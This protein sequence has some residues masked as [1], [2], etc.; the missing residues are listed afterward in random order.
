MIKK[1]SPL[2]ILILGYLAFITIGALLLLMPFTH[3]GELNFT[4]A[5]F[6]STSAVCVTGLIV[7][8]TA[9]FFTPWGKAI[10]LFLLQIG[11]IGYMTVATL[12]LFILKGKTSL[13]FRVTALQSFPELTFSSLKSFFKTIIIITFVLEIAGTFILFLAMRHIYS[14]EHAMFYS[15]FNSVSAFCNAGFSTFAESLVNFRENPA[16]ILTIAFLIISGGIGFYVYI[17]IYHRYIKRDKRRLSLHTK[18]VFITT[19][20]LLIG[21]TLLFLVSEY[22][23]SMMGLSLKSKIL[24]A[25][26]Q[27]VTT[28]TAGF[29]TIDQSRLSPFGA[30]LSMFLMFVGGSPGGTAGGIKTTTILAVLLWQLSY[31]RRKES[32]TL[33]N[34]KIPERQIKKAFSVFVLSGITVLAG[35]LIIAFTE[36]NGIKTHGLTPYLFEIFSAFGT[37]GLSFGSFNTPFVS[38]SHDFTILSKWIII[39]IML[40]GKVGVLSLA[41]SMIDVKKEQIEYP[42]GHYVV[43]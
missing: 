24:Q 14:T 17:D 27:S 13:K 42:E 11:G 10:I 39:L 28:R 40:T 1:L 35:S 6:T 32:T 25:F 3:R 5:F 12:L 23:D 34:Y 7:K 9:H 26:F 15:F 29:N 22:S 21:G 16:I 18:S 41:F 30:L 31:I 38:L 8:D 19:S 20:I 37:V 2:Q 43:G 36:H 4:D 33:I